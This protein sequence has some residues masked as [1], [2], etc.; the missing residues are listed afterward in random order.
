[1]STA[2][3]T[4]VK[5]LIRTR[6]LTFTPATGT[7]LLVR[8]GS[9][10][11]GSGASGKLFFDQAPDNLTG[12]WAV[13]RVID[14]PMAGMDG[15]LMMRGTAELFLYGRPRKMQAQVESMA[16]VCMEAWRDFVYNEIGGHFSATD[17]TRGGAIPYTEPADRE[18]VAIRLL[19]EFR[20]APMFLLQYA[21][22]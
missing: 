1:M 8:L 5:H 12:L 22:T 3:W 2:S 9:T 21:A 16:D 19:L 18:L 7:T 15:R 4:G 11:S 13:L 10:S 14:A 17:V 20:C 6:L